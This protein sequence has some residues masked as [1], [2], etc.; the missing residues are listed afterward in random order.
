M[1]EPPLFQ[2]ATTIYRR[3]KIEPRGVKPMR[4]AEE[5]T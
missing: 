2:W 4:K 5:K 3:R 1:G